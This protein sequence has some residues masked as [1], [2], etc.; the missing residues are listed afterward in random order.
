[1]SVQFFVFFFFVLRCP[2]LQ[3]NISPTQTEK[4]NT[5]YIYKKKINTIATTTTTTYLYKRTYAT[6]AIMILKYLT[7]C[8]TGERHPHSLLFRIRS[9]VKYT[10][11]LRPKSVQGRYIFFQIFFRGSRH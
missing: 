4:Q 8:Y 11:R 3:A 2:L 6:I 1:M 7:R 10:V 9:R 5:L